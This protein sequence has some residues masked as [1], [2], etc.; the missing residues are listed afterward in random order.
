MRI[1]P[2][3]EP[4]GKGSNGSKPGAGSRRQRASEGHAAIALQRA[5]LYAP[6]N[7][8]RRYH[9]QPSGPQPESPAVEARLNVRRKGA[10][11]QRWKTWRPAQKRIGEKGKRGSKA[12]LG[13]NRDR[14]LERKRYVVAHATVCELHPSFDLIADYLHIEIVS[15]L[16]HSTGF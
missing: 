7:L 13:L 9:H 1:L 3:R 16:D 8:S 12:A 10:S 6:Q 2:Y 11:F 4:T 5:L 15:E 14:F